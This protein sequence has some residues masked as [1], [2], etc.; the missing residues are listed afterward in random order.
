[1]FTECSPAEPRCA[2]APPTPT[3]L[4]STTS[5]SWLV[6]LDVVLLQPLLQMPLP[7]MSGLGRALAPARRPRRPRRAPP[8]RAASET[9]SG[10]E[11]V[12]CV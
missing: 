12:Q 6:L 9:Y 4:P 8:R 11:V 10:Q 3:L 2:A 5:R 7:P 1:M